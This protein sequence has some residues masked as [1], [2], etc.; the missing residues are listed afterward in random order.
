MK[1]TLVILCIAFSISISAQSI[2]ASV[3]SDSILIGNTIKV[4]FKIENTEAELEIPSF[5]NISIVNGPNYSNSVQIMNGR[6]T[7]S[8]SISYYLKPEVEGQLFIPPVSVTDGNQILETTAIEINVYPNPDGIITNIEPEGSFFF[9][10][11]DFPFQGFNNNDF[12]KSPFEDMKL[13]KE[14]APKK[15]TKPKSKS[16]EKIRKI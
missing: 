2:K 1:S 11:M 5:E 14:E 4:T 6:K 16:K 3:S 10:S 15:E 8:K 12:F 7:S 9:E 13:E